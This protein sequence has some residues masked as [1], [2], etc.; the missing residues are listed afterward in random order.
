MIPFTVIYHSLDVIWRHW[1]EEK[2]TSFTKYGDLCRPG[3]VA[4]RR[5]S[6]RER[7]VASNRCVAAKPENIS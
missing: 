5:R 4:S 2:A 6:V 7:L 1:K 3:K